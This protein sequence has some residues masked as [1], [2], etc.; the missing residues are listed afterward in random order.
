MGKYTI[1]IEMDSEKSANYLKE[2]IEEKFPLI[3]GKVKI[4]KEPEIKPLNEVI[5][6]LEGGKYVR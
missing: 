1:I 5:E 2:Q 3:E 6:D 4:L